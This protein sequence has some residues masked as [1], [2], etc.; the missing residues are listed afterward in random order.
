VNDLMDSCHCSALLVLE[1]TIVI[2]IGED[3]VDCGGV[4]GLVSGDIE[5]HL[6]NEP[7]SHLISC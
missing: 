7:A 3:I 4:C 1:L 5:R 6:L 2:V